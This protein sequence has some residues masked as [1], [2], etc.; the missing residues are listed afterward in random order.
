VPPGD[1]CH[2][3]SNLRTVVREQARLH[4]KRSFLEAAR[5]P[6]TVSFTDLDAACT[7]WNAW[8]DRHAVAP[9]AR[10]IVDIDDPLSFALVHLGVI[11]AG[12]CS[13]PI[14][15]DAPSADVIRTIAATDPVLVISDR[16][17]RGHTGSLPFVHVA[18]GRSPAPKGPEASAAEPTGPG[19]IRMSTSGSTGEPKTVHLDEGQLLHVARS[20][21]AHNELTP[22]DRGYNCLPLFHINAQVVALLASLVAGATVIL[23]RRFHRSGFWS[24]LRD[25]E[26]TWLNGVPAILAILAQNPEA[27]TLPHLRFVRSASAPLPE[28]IRVATEAVT[29]VPVIESY[30]MT[31]AAS[32]ITAVPLHAPRAGSAGVAVGVEI[33]VRAP[34][35]GVG[36]IWIRGAGV[37]TGY[38]GGRAGERFDDDGWLQTG[39]LGHLDNDG[40]LFLAGRADDVI[41]RGGELIYPREV[42]EVL[43]GDSRVREAAVVGEPHPILG[44]VP[45][46]YVLAPQQAIDDTGRDALI[47]E[48]ERRC[49]EQL[50]RFKCPARFEVVAELPRA[51]TGKIRRRDLREL[52]SAARP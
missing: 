32:Q 10:V 46:A 29:G 44:Q 15:P 9:G 28:A 27:Q 51:S 19:A 41:N 11:S 36:Q 49:A 16:P 25:R 14:D 12:R 6:R 31:E 22:T 38:V 33:Q 37:I 40:Y 39:D 35:N 42:E 8:L 50:S 7:D 43:L 45:V 21:A 13:V 52:S 18:D 20:I 5:S 4:R 48:L 47:A 3:A 2:S 34:S 30:G 23:D 26:V 17:D 1:Y 24:L